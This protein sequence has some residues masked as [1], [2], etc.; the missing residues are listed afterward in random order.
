MVEYAEKAERFMHG[1]GLADFR[2]DEQKVLAV[3]RALEVIGGRG[4]RGREPFLRKFKGSF[5]PNPQQDLG[6]LSI[7]PRP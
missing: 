2:K 6:A 4:K 3:V 7:S 5:S 1:C